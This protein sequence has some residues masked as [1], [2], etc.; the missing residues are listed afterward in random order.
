MIRRAAALLALLALFACDKQP[1]RIL[2]QS[3][4][5]R[6]GAVLPDLV[7]Q[8]LEGE[9][10]RLSDF[11]ETPVLINFWASWCKPCREEFPLLKETVSKGGVEV[12]G[13]VFDDTDQR[14]LAFKRK[15]EAT[16]PTVSDP[17]GRIAKGF[18]VTRPP[19]IPQTAFIA[20]GRRFH[21]KILGE[22]NAKLIADTLAEMD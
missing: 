10:V 5:A 9:V 22:L 18:R 14:A 21:V 6:E 11:E 12:I 17:Q 1:E 13:V 16:W 7:M 8:T 2:T 3:F 19:G 20:P 15:L 4:T